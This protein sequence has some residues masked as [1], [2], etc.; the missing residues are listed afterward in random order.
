GDLL[1]SG[2]SAIEDRLQN[3][4]PET[5]FKLRRAGI[6][7]WMLTGDKVETAINIAKSCRLID[8]D[9][10]ET[11]SVDVNTTAT[12][13]AV[14]GSKNGEKEKEKMLLLVMQSITDHDELDKII[15]NALEAARNMAANSSIDDRFE[16]R[17]RREKLRRGMKMFGNMLDPRRLR[18]RRRTSSSSSGNTSGNG[19]TK[20]ANSTHVERPAIAGVDLQRPATAIEW[21]SD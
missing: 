8:T 5:I 9:V 16:K 12:T 10:V 11:T 6:R 20:D 15:S 17:S 21:A 3:G 14:G 13:A 2:V 1:L 7:V 4:V 18:H 19:Q